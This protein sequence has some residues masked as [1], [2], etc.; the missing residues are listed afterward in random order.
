MMEAPKIEKSCTK[1]SRP[2][3]KNVNFSKALV[4]L[5]FWKGSCQTLRYKQICC[6]LCNQKGVFINTSSYNAHITRW[7][8]PSLSNHW[9]VLVSNLFCHFLWLQEVSRLFLVTRVSH[10]F[11]VLHFPTSV[12]PFSPPISILAR[13]KP[14]LIQQLTAD[15]EK[16]T[17]ISILNRSFLNELYMKIYVVVVKILKIKG[18]DSH[19][20]CGSIVDDNDPLSSLVVPSKTD[21]DAKCYYQLDKSWKIRRLMDV[22]RKK[23]EINDTAVLTLMCAKSRS[24]SVKS[25]KSA[26]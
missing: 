18:R 13:P 24:E 4:L 16:A 12:S 1:G 26:R 15:I 9:R 10:I 6:F 11:P 20:W 23:G 17:D 5:R 3:R 22:A 2:S 14:I 25:G 7:Q 8:N 21:E 19:W